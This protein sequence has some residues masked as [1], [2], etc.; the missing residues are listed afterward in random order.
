V[1]ACAAFTHSCL[2]AVGFILGAFCVLMVLA[3][4]MN[5]ADER[6]VKD[7]AAAR[8]RWH[9]FICVTQGTKPEPPGLEYL[10]EGVNPVERP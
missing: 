8:S 1:I 3:E 10:R 6:A 2:P 5:R 4:V 7:V 9:G